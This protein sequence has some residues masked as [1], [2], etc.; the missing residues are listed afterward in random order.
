MSYCPIDSALRQGKHIICK[1]LENEEMTSCQK[2]AY[3]LGFRSSASFPLKVSDI[4]KGALTF[5]SDQQDFFDEAELKL[6]DELAMDISFAMEYAEKEASRLRAEEALND[7]NSNLEQRV[8]N[9]TMELARSKQLLDETGR[10]ARVGGWELD[11]M[12]NNLYWSEMTYKI[13]EVDPG[14]VPELESGINF[15]APEAV[16]VI[17]QCVEKAIRIGESF[18]VELELITAKQNRLWVRAI[19][20]AY[21]ENG[22]IVKVG[23][24]FQDIN[25]SKLAD[26]KLKKYR[27]QLDEQTSQLESSNKELEAFSYSVSHDLRAPLRH[28]SG[29]VELLNKHFQSDLPEKGKHYLNSIA[30]S[31]RVMGVLIDDLLQFSRTGRMEMRHSD[32]DM[33]EI[34]NEVIKSLRIENPDRKIEWIQKKLPSVY[35]D[36]AML[37]LVWI[38]LLSNAVK[39]TR[40]KSKASIEIG[41]TPEN[42]E[43]IFFVRDNGVG[44]DMQYA[45]KLF[46]VFQRLHS[47]EEFEGTGIGLANVQRIILRHGGRTWAEAEPD[48][49][50]VFFFSI[51][52]K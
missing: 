35:G 44:F 10:L 21:R 48:K 52:K 34:M 17:S 37:R 23:G 33:N 16:P 28:I 2:I 40:T 31:V 8:L 20:E 6:L 39:F 14:F 19:G 4:M 29:Y 41:F 3:K 51:P 25:K 27:D 50:A 18:D 12:T 47:T 1:I 5:Y 42:K 7:A 15:Y 24:V 11:I 43:L 45:Q 13:H 36:T 38:N 49:G 22:E 26:I 32:V 9:R 46:G 30:D